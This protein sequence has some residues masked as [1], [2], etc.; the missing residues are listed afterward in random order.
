[1]DY[2]ARNSTK[3]TEQNPHKQNPLLTINTSPQT[4]RII[5][6][7]APDDV[8]D[9]ADKLPVQT[10]P[11]IRHIREP[12]LA[13]STTTTLSNFLTTSKSLG[14][15][16]VQ[17]HQRCVTLRRSHPTTKTYSTPPTDNLSVTSVTPS[18]ATS[19]ATNSSCFTTLSNPTEC[20]AL[21]KTLSP[22]C[23]NRCNL[24]TNS[25]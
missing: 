3:L 25:P 19:G 5:F 14:I 23:T 11:T 13:T 15:L 17:F 4:A 2:Q 22:A 18:G 16:A 20:A 8:A 1:M 10:T 24:A 12:S 21:N 9:V 6:I 7:A